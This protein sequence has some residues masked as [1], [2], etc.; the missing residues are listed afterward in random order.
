MLPL[1]HTI[2]PD[3][4]GRQALVTLG[5]ETSVRA[6]ATLMAERKI[7]AVLILDDKR[8]AGIFTER[9]LLTRVVVPGRDPDKTALAEVMTRSP[10]VLRP[11]DTVATALDMMNKHGYRHLPVLDGNDLVGIVSVRDLFHSVKDQMEAD[12]ILLA[13]A[14]IQG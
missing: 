13:E 14:L 10:D 7:G 2:V 3:V 12:I 6:A 9:D 1:E 5:G 11:D 8:L 4:I